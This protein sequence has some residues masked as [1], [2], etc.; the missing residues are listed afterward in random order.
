MLTTGVIT[1]SGVFSALFSL[2]IPLS[3]MARCAEFPYLAAMVRSA[4]LGP[5]RLRVSRRFVQPLCVEPEKGTPSAKAGQAQ[6][7][8]GRPGAARRD[9]RRLAALWVGGGPGR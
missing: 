3:P 7:L 2:D 9:G 6:V 5:V 8:A 1:T 4:D